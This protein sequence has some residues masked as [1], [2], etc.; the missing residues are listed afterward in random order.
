MDMHKATEITLAWELFEQGIPKTHI[1]QQLGKNRDTILQWI[2]G[3]EKYGLLE[4]LERYEGAKKGE[5]K[6]RK[7]TSK[8]KD[9]VWDIRREEYDCCGQKV[10]YYLRERHEINL[11][12]QTIYEILNEKFEIKSK[13]K[14]GTVIK[15]EAPTAEKKRE[16]VQ[17]DTI[18]FGEIFAF[19]AVDI[20]G[21]DAD[22]FMAPALTG[23]YG[24]QFLEF[25]M[26]RRFDGYVNTIQTDGGPEF[27][28][29]FT[30]KVLNYCEKRRVARAYKK[31][32][33]SYIESFNRTVR[34]ECLGWQ[35]YRYEQLDE[36]QKLIES[37]LERY[38]YRRPHMSLGMQPPLK[39]Q[40]NRLPD[41]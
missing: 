8:I 1:S 12:V 29:E 28:K 21:R 20:V 31:N 22:V 2:Q 24:A 4:F 3:I 14:K 17:M 32:E 27:K 39:L 9:M 11:S 41:F 16:V 23:D 5:R 13:W 10:Q 7:V 6:K 36:C 30:E 40:I 15:G 18:D 34:K 35:K 26:P 25:S 33:Q 38:H 19:T 37:F